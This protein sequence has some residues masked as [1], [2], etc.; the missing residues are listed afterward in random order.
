MT[1]PPSVDTL[2]KRTRRYWYEDGLTDLALGAYFL[3]LAVF[4]WAQAKTPLGSSVWLLWG[5]GGPVLLIGG[6]LM[7]D[8]LVKR[9]K[10]EITHPR[11]G[12]VSYQQASPLRPTAKRAQVMVLAALIGAAF[13]IVS[14]E[15][16]D[17]TLLF[18]LVALGTFG[19][20]S[21]R[22]GLW[23]Y[24]FLGVWGL[25]LALFLVLAALPP[26]AEE[27]RAVYWMG[28]A[29]GMLVSGLI[30]WHRYNRSAPSQQEAGD[31]SNP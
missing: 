21:Y 3:A 15:W 26:A 14:K 1:A 22:V 10:D 24:L 12:Y 18:G 11:T 31:E 13:V 2:M 23:R 30:A 6:G 27:R 17:E 29:L 9:L 25:L 19:Y 7:V 4:F 5:L 20:V 16:V 28:L 8:W